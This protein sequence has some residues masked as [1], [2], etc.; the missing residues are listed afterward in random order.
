MKGSRMGCHRVQDKGGVKV[1]DC[2][3]GEGGGRVLSVVSVVCKDVCRA[4]F[5]S[6]D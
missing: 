5:L 2:V 1:V 3:A 6:L 4:L